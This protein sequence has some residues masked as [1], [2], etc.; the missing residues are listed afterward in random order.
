MQ[1]LFRIIKDYHNN[2]SN[3]LGSVLERIKQIRLTLH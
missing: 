1:E 3:L 2:F